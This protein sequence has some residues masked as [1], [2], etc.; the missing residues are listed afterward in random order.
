MSKMSR[1]CD[2]SPKVKRRVW[3]RD[4][5]ACILCG[6]PKA[7]PNAHY[8]RRS[9][10]GLGVVQNVVT[11]CAKCH[12]DFDNGDKR[13]EYGA[14]ISSYLKGWYPK[15]NEKDIVYNKYAFLEVDDEAGRESED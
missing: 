8:I 5:H 12:H 9:K 15:W 11:L 2:I 13:Q 4:G 1:A 10:G 7:M 3:D 6:N 14:I